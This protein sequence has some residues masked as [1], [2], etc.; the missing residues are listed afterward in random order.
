MNTFLIV[1]LS[2]IAILQLLIA[3]PITLL[4]ISLVEAFKDFRVEIQEELL[5]NLSKKTKKTLKNKK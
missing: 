2:I 5:T 1:I 4:M 3:V